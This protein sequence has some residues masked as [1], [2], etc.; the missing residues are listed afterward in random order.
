MSLQFRMGEGLARGTARIAREQIGEAIEQLE[1]ASSLISRE[2]SIHEARKQIKKARALLRLARDPIGP[3]RA[4]KA[5]RQLRDAAQ[6]LSVARDASALIGAIDKLGADLDGI[7]STVSFDP[8]RDFLSKRRDRVVR[9]SLDEQEVL[10]TAISALRKARRRIGRWDLRGGDSGPL[11][12]L[13]RSYKRARAAAEIASEARSPEAFHEW[14][15]RVKD[16]GYQVRAITET[17]DLDARLRQ[18]GEALGDLHDLD[19]LEA[20][21]PYSVLGPIRS[22]IEARREQ[23]RSFTLGRAVEIFAEKPAIFARQL[24]RLMSST[25]VASSD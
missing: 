3:R 25:A 20:T 15:K 1:A 16:L 9:D 7:D 4:A 12:G 13:K 5:I 10:P 17:G 24:S 11:A 23:L 14:R 2:T 21:L 22:T 18:L 6:P 8:A 19:I